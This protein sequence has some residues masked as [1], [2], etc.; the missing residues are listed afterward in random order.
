MPRYRKPQS[1]PTQLSQP[2][3]RDKD[4]NLHE[5]LEIPVPSKADVF[6]DLERFARRRG[7]NI[8]KNADTNWV[9]KNNRKASFL[10]QKNCCGIAP[11]MSYYVGADKR[12][13]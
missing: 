13:N 1:G 12:H 6:G 8:R 9:I 7:K 4:G 5:S 2:K 3:G 11:T 10:E